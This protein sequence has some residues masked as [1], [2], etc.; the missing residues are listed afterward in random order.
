MREDLLKGL[1]A[2]QIAKVRACEDV[3]DLFQ[4]AKDEGVELSEE[5]L[6]AINGGGCGQPNKIRCPRC[7]CE[8]LNKKVSNNITTF[9]C[10]D[11]GY[12]WSM[13]GSF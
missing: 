6:D 10:Q 2:E 12:E 11:C 9:T 4:L 8:R 3:A 13:T 7:N 1:T 5:Q